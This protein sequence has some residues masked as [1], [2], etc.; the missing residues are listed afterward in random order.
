MRALDEEPISDVEAQ[1][2]VA[3]L[4]LNVKAMAAHIRQMIAAR[5]D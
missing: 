5:D 3:D 1:E 4:K 2:A